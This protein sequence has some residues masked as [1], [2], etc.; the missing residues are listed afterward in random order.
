[1]AE[2]TLRISEQTY[3]EKGK[4]FFEKKRNTKKQY[5]S[6][7]RPSNLIQILMEPKKALWKRKQQER[8]N[9]Y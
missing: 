7:T 2:K 4:E 9:A 1:M 8:N 5:W 6:L 3:I